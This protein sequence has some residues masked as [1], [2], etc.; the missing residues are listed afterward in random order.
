MLF[1]AK[2]FESFAVSPAC[3]CVIVLVWSMDVLYRL[4]G[5][6]SE[7][8]LSYLLTLKVYVIVMIVRVCMMIMRSVFPRGDSMTLPYLYLTWCCAFKGCKSS[9]CFV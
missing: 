6:G 1:S 2:C 9:P 7:G 8:V 4:D 3:F 5:C